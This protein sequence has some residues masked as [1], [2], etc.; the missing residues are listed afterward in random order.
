MDDT[1]ITQAGW[2]ERFDEA[3]QKQWNGGNPYWP[4]W[5]GVKSFIRAEIISAED[6]AYKA[7]EASGEV[8]ERTRYYQKPNWKELNKDWYY[9]FHDADETMDGFL[10]IISTVDLSEVAKIDLR[11]IFFNDQ[12]SDVNK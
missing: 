2:E 12:R 11:H 3:R 7:G 4:D 8:K 10:R 1:D 9:T 5:D 6:E